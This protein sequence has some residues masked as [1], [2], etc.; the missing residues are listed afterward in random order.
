MA[1]GYRIKK[2]EQAMSADRQPTL[3]LSAQ[4][5]RRLVEAMEEEGKQEALALAEALRDRWNI[6]KA[7]PPTTPPHGE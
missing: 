7:T 3:R 5:A 1:I 6:S 2:L 4:Q